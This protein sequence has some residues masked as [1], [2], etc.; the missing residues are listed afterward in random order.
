MAGLHGDTA[1]VVSVN[2]T[3]PV[4]VGVKVTNSGLAVW[5][6]VLKDPLPEVTDH[7]P[8][9]APPPNVAP[10]SVIVANWHITSGPPALAVGADVTLIVLV[11]LV[12][13]HGPAP[14]G[15]F[16]VNVSTTVPTVVGVKVT[17]AGLPVC[18]IVLKVPVPEVIDHA[19]VVA[20]PPTLAP[21][22]ANG[23]ELWQVV[24]VPPVFTVAAAFTVMVLSSV[25]AVQVPAGSLVVKRNVTV[26]EELGV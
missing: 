19:P 8:V 22:S 15:S 9:V 20:P 3:V 23:V 17:D 26:P 12:A 18:A 14:S 24:T 7:A 6:T 2:C 25:T 1:L 13:A 11:A 4:D 5:A 16:V 21:V 10:D